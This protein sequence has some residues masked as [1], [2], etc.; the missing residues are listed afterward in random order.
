M[1]H[2]PEDRHKHG[3]VLDYSL[4]E[5][6]VLQRYFEPRFQKH[7]FIRFDAVRSYAEGLIKLFDVRS[8][9][10]TATVARSMS[11][12]NQ[13]K[14]IVAREMDRE[15]KLLV[16]VQP[17]RGLDVGAIEYI[18]KQ[19]V[20]SRDAGTAVLLVSL[21]LEEVM[22]L[23]DRILVMYEGEIVGEP[24]PKTTTVQELGLYMAGAKR[25][26]REEAAE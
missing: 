25:Q 10:G 19:I 9:Q 2:I 24:D 12:G 15:H 17:T 1:S 5:N 3:L 16:A 11:G 6:M 20:N 26:S 22:S 21:E 8:G 13:Q 14:A 7:G 18:H 23:S 4:G